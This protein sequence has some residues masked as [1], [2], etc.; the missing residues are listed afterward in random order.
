MRPVG[1][2]QVVAF[3]EVHGAAVEAE[4]LPGQLHGFA[5]ECIHLVTLE[6]FIRNRHQR[7]QPAG[8]EALALLGLPAF[9][10]VVDVDSKPHDTAILAQ[11]RV[12]RGQEVAIAASLLETRRLPGT[13]DHVTALAASLDHRRVHVFVDI[14]PDKVFNALAEG[15][16]AGIVDRKNS[17]VGINEECEIVAGVEQ[18][19]RGILAGAKGCLGF[20]AG[21]YVPRNSQD[22][23]D[24]PRP[25]Q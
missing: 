19:P 1:P 7:S 18:S 24:L 15:P 9:G 13:Q 5:Q 16:R 12:D 11:H 25:I 21:G 6:Q 10:D 4:G 3:R 23:G 22:R 8:H 14:S 17:P 2:A 20:A